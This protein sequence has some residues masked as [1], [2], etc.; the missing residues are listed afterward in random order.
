MLSW[1]AQHQCSKLELT[2]VSESFSP[3][4]GRKDHAAFRSCWATCKNFISLGFSDALN[5]VLGSFSTLARIQLWEILCFCFALQTMIYHNYNVCMLCA[6]F[7]GK[8]GGWNYVISFNFGEEIFV[9]S[10]LISCFSIFKNMRY[11]KIELKAAACNFFLNTVLVKTY[12]KTHLIVEMCS[13]YLPWSH[14]HGT[15]LAAM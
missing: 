13:G 15:A 2:V 1:L 12:L 8:I 14:T 4:I 9:K 3:W 11:C 5:A 10:V 6:T 7:W